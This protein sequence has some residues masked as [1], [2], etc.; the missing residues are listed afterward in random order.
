[1]NDKYIL[2]AEGN[3]IPE[4]DLMKWGQWLQTAKRNIAKTDLP[5]GLWVSTVFLGLDHQF[6]PG[7]PP[8]IFETMIFA[9]GSSGLS[10]IAGAT[11]PGLKLWLGIR[12]LWP[13]PELKFARQ[14]ESLPLTGG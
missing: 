7:E 14:A 10:F 12:K 11:A 6:E 1:M 5:N 9:K 2:N 13:G 3:P 4:P 8:L